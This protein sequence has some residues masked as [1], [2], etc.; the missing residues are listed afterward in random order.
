MPLSVIRQFWWFVRKFDPAPPQPG[1]LWLFSQKRI[2][3]YLSFSK[4]RNNSPHT[5][6]NKAKILQQ[7]VGWLMKESNWSLCTVFKTTLWKVYNQVPLLFF[8]SF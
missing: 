3:A 1:W 6:A 8:S 2:E 4:S 5:L 7:L